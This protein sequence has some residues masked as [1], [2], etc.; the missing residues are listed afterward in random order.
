MGLEPA[1]RSYRLAAEHARA[2]GRGDL[3]AAAAL[4]FAHRPNSSGYGD[5]E[6][7]EVLERAASA[8][9]ETEE[10]LRIRLESRLAAEIRYDDRP[11]AEALADGAIAAARRLGDPAVLA[12]VLDD[13]CYVRW[14]PADPPA[15]IALNAEVARVA[16]SS[17]DSELVLEGLKGCVT[18][19]L[20]V[21]DLAAVDR[22]IRACE[23]AADALRT[24]YSSWLCAAMLA[25]RALLDGDLAAAERRVGEAIRIGARVDSAE[26]A[27]EL[28]TQFVGLRLEQGRAAEIESAAR[29]Q[30][31]RFPNAPAW[32]AALARI[33]L[34]AGRLTEARDE[35]AWLVRQHFADVPRDRGWLPTLAL[36][37]EV[38]CATGDVRTAEILEELLAPYAHL[39]V[40]AGTGV[41][42]YGSVS[43]HLGLLALAQSHWDGAIGHFESALASEE[44]VRARIWAART[45]IFRA[46]ALLGR[47]APGDRP[48]AAALASE[49]MVTARSHALVAVF[50]EARDLEAS[51]WARRRVPRTP[52]NAK[53]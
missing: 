53:S 1:R 39:A 43:H 50:E 29:S 51:V 8:L 22:E 41:L 37:S 24:P 26:V 4:G 21:G 23:R 9:D 10:A 32:R 49:A 6:T 47:D 5:R 27:L 36:A 14:S 12:Q 19:W 18:G 35:L 45:R 25:M 16:H 52:R 31:E 13:T 30:V 38:A 2:A 28:Q 33:L 42:Y 48:R 40:V 20:E 34:S 17:N 15:W 7:I 46:R 11:R 3:L 44:Q